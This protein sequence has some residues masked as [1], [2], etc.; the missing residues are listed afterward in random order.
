MT[1]SQALRYIHA[2]KTHGARPGLH[3]ILPLLEKLGRPQEGMPVL[4]VAGTNGKGSTA[5]ML[6]AVLR[7]AG[8]KTGCFTSPFIYDF[9]ERYAING[10]I[11]SEKEL[12]ET[13]ARVKDAEDAL[14]AEGL[15]RPT[16]FEIVTAIGLL[17][18]K[19][20][21]VTVL[22]VGLGGRFDATNVVENPLAAVLCSISLDHT[23][24]LGDTVGK[25]AREKAGIIKPGRPAVLCCGN[26]E[27]ALAE[28]RARCAALDAPL[29]LCGQPESCAADVNGSRFVY[30]GESYSIA[31]RGEHQIHNAIT[32]IETLEYLKNTGVLSYTASQ[33]KQGLQKAY[34]PSRLECIHQDPYIFIDGGHNREGIDILLRAM[35]TMKEL[36]DPVI[37][38]GMMQDKPYQYAVRKLAERARA[39]LTVQPPVPRAMT[40]YDLNNIASLYCDDT[41]AC[42]GYEEAARLAQKKC[43]GSILVAGSLY[44][45]G[46]MT[47]ALK[48]IFR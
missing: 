40:A 46:A 19:S 31:L 42:S 7:E 48:K 35:D 5:T 18:F 21:D 41:A 24:Y 16:E 36:R 3:R 2:H 12:A 13:A 29:I 25:I 6:A 39:F 15:E 43:G 26:P 30:K 1:Y 17:F 45:T 34:L 37:I 11:I 23:A 20:C 33:L 22:E 28:I 44:I 38:F 14:L 27:E 10:V 32:A 8:Y 47:T 4:H 9:R